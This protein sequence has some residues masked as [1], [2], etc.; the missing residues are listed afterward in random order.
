MV[1]YGRIG[2]EKGIDILMKVWNNLEIPFVVM[3]GG[4][5]EKDLKKWADKNPNVYYMGYTEHEKCLNI[6][7]RSEFVV[8]PS[9]WYEGCSMVEIEAMSLGK[10]V[11]ATDLG[12][13]KEAII[14]GY[15]GY[16][17]PLGDVSEFKKKICELWSSS[18]KCKELGINARKEYEEKYRP[19]DNY[20]QLMRIYKSALRGKT[21]AFRN[22]RNR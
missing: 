16:K 8:F 18:K 12:F 14:D 22:K 15:N 5:L 10:G 6:V 2:K 19:E 7:K 13:S 21:N 20:Q 9:I 3:G 17:F 11:I 4:P 1:F